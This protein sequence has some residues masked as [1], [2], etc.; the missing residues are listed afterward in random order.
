MSRLGRFPL[1]AVLLCLSGS[2]LGACQ[3]LAGISDRS[4]VAGGDAGAAG[5]DSGP[6]AACQ[7]YCTRIMAL[8][9]KPNEA[10]TDL[11]TCLGIC[12]LIPPGDVVE[13]TGNTLA[14]RVNELAIQETAGAEASSLP[15]ACVR[16]GPGGGGKCGSNCESYCLLYK[17]ACQ[18]ELPNLTDTQY[19]P[20]LCVA[21]CQGLKDT[22]SFDTD[23]N[24][25]G[26]TLQCR[27]VH[28]SA[29]S[30]EPATHCPH[31]QLQ[32]QNTI[33]PKGPCVDDVTIPP[34]CDSFCQLEMT[35]CQGANAI[36]A[37]RDQ[38]IAVCK[39]LPEGSVDDTKENSVGCRRYHSYNAMFKP[40]VHCSHTGPGGDGHCGD[41]ATGNCESYCILA[42]AAC[43]ATVPGVTLTKTFETTYI[44]TAGC[45]KACAKL[46]GAVHDSGY[47]LDAKGANVQCLLLHASKALS[48]PADDC[49]AALGDAPCK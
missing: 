11:S 6:S 49:A 5:S 29:A 2:A 20:D 16:S 18:T 14:C 48:T 27:L 21:A 34:D 44:N 35:E 47:S 30:V 37:D 32:A 43:S 8:C 22:N 39:A 19:D 28:T 7:D 24:Y 13:K 9:T 38:C 17:G 12:A 1:F 25:T 45:Q 46:P 33:M 15:D 36:Y 31:A 10:Y 41:M 42:K 4:F 3:A 40:E 23:A 26:D